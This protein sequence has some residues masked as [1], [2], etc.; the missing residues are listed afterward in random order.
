M[1]RESFLEEF[2]KADGPPQIVLFIMLVALAFGSTIGV[3]SCFVT[4][5]RFGVTGE[6]PSPA[7]SRVFTFGRLLC[8]SLGRDRDMLLLE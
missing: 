7:R 2:T 6:A 5:L 1:R 4:K 8:L 3:V